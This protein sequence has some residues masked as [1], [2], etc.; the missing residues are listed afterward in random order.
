MP[1]PWQRR[2]P[3]P[4]DPRVRKIGNALADL[5]KKMR[6]EKAAKK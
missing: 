3:P 2:H 1:K 4:K 5:V 6:E